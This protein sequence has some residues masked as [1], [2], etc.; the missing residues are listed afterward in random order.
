MEFLV[1]EAKVNVNAKDKDGTDALMSAS[2]RGHKEVVELLLKHGAQVNTQNT[3]GHTALMFAYNGKNQVASL[4]DKYG[5]YLQGENDNNTR[6]IREALDT[7]VKV[8]QVRSCLLGWR[9]VGVVRADGWEAFH[10]LSSCR[11][12]SCY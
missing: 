4:L 2:V 6:I 3:D 7:H 10:C 9:G 5:E 8:G 1:T 11:W 12:W